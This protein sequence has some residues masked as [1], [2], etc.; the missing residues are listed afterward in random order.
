VQFQ[1]LLEPTGFGQFLLVVEVLALLVVLVVGHQI[2]VRLVV[3][4]VD[5][6]LVG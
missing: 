1:F 6:L 5:I 4:L 3:V 2:L